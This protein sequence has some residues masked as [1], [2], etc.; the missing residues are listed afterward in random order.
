MLSVTNE[1]TLILIISKAVM[2]CFCLIYGCCTLSGR[3]KQREWGHW[4][5]TINVSPPTQSEV[6]VAEPPI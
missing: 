3:G 6:I 2:H 5:A 4:I 1:M